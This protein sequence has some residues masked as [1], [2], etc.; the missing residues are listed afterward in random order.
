MGFNLGSISGLVSGIGTLGGGALSLFGKKK[1]A[2]TTQIP[3]FTPGQQNM[4]AQLGN[5]GMQGLQRLQNSNNSFEPIADLARSRFKTDTI[6]SLAERFTAFGEGGQRGSDF[7]GAA[8]G[9]GADLEGQLAAQGSQYGLQQQ[10][11]QQG[12]IQQLLNMS[13]R[14]QFDN[15][16]Q[17]EQMGGAQ[18]FGSNLFNA[19]LPM[20]GKSFDMYNAQKQS[21]L[22]GRQWDAQQRGGI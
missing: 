15:V 11:L 21:D 12:L 17:P 10:G 6:P 20:M 5:I 9:A 4:M 22:L 2:Q 3:N 19:S 13:L 7:Q 8:A 16:H 1:P 18:R 14:P